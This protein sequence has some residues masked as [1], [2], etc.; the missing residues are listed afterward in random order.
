MDMDMDMGMGMGMDMDMDV[1]MDMDMDM[2]PDIDM[3][4]QTSTKAT[5]RAA[6]TRGGAPGRRSARRLPTS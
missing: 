4:S 1:D 5:H 3:V 6:Q 2:G